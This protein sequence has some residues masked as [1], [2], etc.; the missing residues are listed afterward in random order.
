[1]VQVGSAVGRREVV[2]KALFRIMSQTRR[3]EFSSKMPGFPPPFTR[4]QALRGNS[5]TFQPDL[6]M[7]S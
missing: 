7:N 6:D 4:G 2:S 3:Q 1:M 5:N